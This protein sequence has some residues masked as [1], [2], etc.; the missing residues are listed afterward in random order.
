[1]IPVGN[2]QQQASTWGVNCRTILKDAYNNSPGGNPGVPYDTQ[3]SMLSDLGTR[4][5]RTTFVTDEDG[6][7]N[8]QRYEDLIGPLSDPT[9]TAMIPQVRAKGMRVIAVIQDR[10]FADSPLWSASDSE[11]YD[12][13]YATAAG[14]ATAYGGLCDY[15]ELGNEI[16]LFRGKMTGAGPGTQASHYVEGAVNVIGQYVSGLND[17]VK[18]VYPNKKTIFNTKGFWTTYEWEQVFA[19]AEAHEKEIDYLGLHWYSEMP[20]ALNSLIGTDNPFPTIWNLLE[21]KVWVTELGSRWDNGQ[22]VQWNQERQQGFFNSFM[23]Q[24][25][26]SGIAVGV[27]YHEL[28]DSVLSNGSYN[29]D[30]QNYGLVRFGNFAENRFSDPRPKLLGGQ[31]GL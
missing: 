13:A 23:Q 4:S 2:I 19:I 30:E 9:K 5:W 18:S 25:R 14:F 29:T 21:K 22:S 11:I 7:L 10:L 16:E 20:G 12:S 24:C 1:M 31:L 6:T 28:L 26:E 3:L 17:G 27:N 8:A 15:F